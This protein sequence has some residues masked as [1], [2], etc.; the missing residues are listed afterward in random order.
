MQENR[1]SDRYAR[2]QVDW[3]SLKEYKKNGVEIHSNSLRGR[4]DEYFNKRFWTKKTGFDVPMMK[5]NK[6]LWMSITPLEVQS[7]ILPVSR[8]WGYVGTGGLGMGYFALKCAEK[9]DVK[10]IKVYEN[11]KDVIE[12]FTQSFSHRIGFEKIKIF[13][14]DA[15][16]IKNESFSYFFMDIYPDQLGGQIL[17][18]CNNFWKKGNQAGFYDMWCQEWALLQYM[19]DDGDNLFLEADEQILFGEFFE[20][21][22]DCTLEDEEPMKKYRLY[23]ALHDK[24]FVKEIVRDYLGRV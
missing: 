12:F 7:M 9:D 15:R 24:A 4:C 6:G 13:E 11:N 16:D 22:M 18:D 1:F 10:E 14:M 20:S 2:Q 17:L 8:A 23:R 19:L 3:Y 5:I 21:E